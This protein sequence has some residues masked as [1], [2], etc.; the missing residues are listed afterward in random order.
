MTTMNIYHRIQQRLY[1]GPLPPSGSGGSSCIREGQE[2]TQIRLHKI[3]G[4]LPSDGGARECVR[5][6]LQIGLPRFHAY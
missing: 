5:S 3:Y 2:R 4:V 1:H 6:D